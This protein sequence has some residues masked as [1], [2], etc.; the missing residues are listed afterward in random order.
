[1]QA[2][3]AWAT[4]QV[5][6]LAG[7]TLILAPEAMGLP[8]AVPLSLATGIPYAV[9][10]KRKYGLPGEE[11]AYCETGYSESCLH[12]NDARPDDRVVVVDDV[13]STGNTLDGILGTLAAMRVP[14]QGALVFVDKGTRRAFLEERHR[15]PVRA[16]RSVRIE[17]GKVVLLPG[18][19]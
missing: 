4:A 7:A 10:R 14:V 1:M 8:L 5:D 13:V 3:L 6:V 15:V 12:I 17:K 2:W 19:A 16:L 11:V 18:Q 9:I